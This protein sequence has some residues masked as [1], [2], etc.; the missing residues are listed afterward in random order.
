M[1]NKK[2]N[3]HY[4]VQTPPLRE[5]PLVGGGCFSRRTNNLVLPILCVNISR[6]AGTLFKEGVGKSRGEELNYA[7]YNGILLKI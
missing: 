6:P 2:T 5:V 3:F 4:K 1:L 7:S